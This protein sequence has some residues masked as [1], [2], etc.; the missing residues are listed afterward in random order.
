[1]GET[2][3]RLLVLAILT[4]VQPSA[5]VGRHRLPKVMA[6]ERRKDL[7]VRE[8]EEVGVV[9]A[10]QGFAE[11]GGDDDERGEVGVGVGVEAVDVGDGALV[12]ASSMPASNSL[13]SA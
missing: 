12:D 1:M 10:D 5:N 9:L 13:S 3:L 7:R 6:T 11:I 8:V 2:A 4:V